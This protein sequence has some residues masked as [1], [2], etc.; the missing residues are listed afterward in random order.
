[1]ERKFS[2]IEAVISKVGWSGK[3]ERPTL[4]ASKLDE[5]GRVGEKILLINVT[6]F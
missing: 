3:R 5:E 2:H 1:L 4:E 6:Q